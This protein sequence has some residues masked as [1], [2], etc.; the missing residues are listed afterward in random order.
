MPSLK[1]IKYFPNG[2]YVGSSKHAHIIDK[3]LKKGLTGYA[4]AKKYNLVR[5]TVY[6]YINKY[7]NDR[8][9]KTS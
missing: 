1:N 8:F 6:N 5:K 2:K 9:K 7:K 3:E 4:I